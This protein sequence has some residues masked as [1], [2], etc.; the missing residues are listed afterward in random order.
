MKYPGDIKLDYT[1]PGFDYPEIVAQ[2]V[3]AEDSQEEGFLEQRI[4]LAVAKRDKE[5]ADFIA[6]NFSQDFM[7]KATVVKEYL[8]TVGKAED[9]I[10]I[11]DLIN[12]V[13]TALPQ[14]A[15]MDTIT[16]AVK[17]S[18]DRKRK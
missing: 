8:K 4:A 14:V 16:R 17:E 13:I 9:S 15:E 10:T 3:V 18:M 1:P 11:A 7:N 2:A 6:Q 5:W 12:S